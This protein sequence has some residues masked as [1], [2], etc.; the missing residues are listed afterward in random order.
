MNTGYFHKEYARSIKYNAKTIHL[1]ESEAWLLKRNIPYTG[2]FDVANCYPLLCCQNWD[3]LK[4]DIH[5]LSKKI[6]SLSIVTDPFAEIEKSNIANTFNIFKPFKKHFIVDL[7][8]KN[9]FN[10]HH[11]R[12]ISRSLKKNIEL[13]HCENPLEYIDQWDSLY[14]GLINRHNI[15]KSISFSRSLF[16]NQFKVPGIFVFR[17]VRDNETIGMAL[18]YVSNRNAYY[19]LTA[20]SDIGYKTGCSYAL[21]N[22]SLNFFRENGTYKA[23]LG[24]GSGL[25]EN[26]NDGLTKFKAGWS[27]Y[28]KT[29]FFCGKIINHCE[30]DNIIKKSKNYSSF[31]A[32]RNPNE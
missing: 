11:K 20:Y 3:K 31:P 10:L 1:K 7:K 12:E 8:S 21:M 30:Y 6:V 13:E 26:K 19:H 24:S 15:R 18:W 32:Y 29:A 16:I 17:A 14:T 28:T 2:L 27:N 5:N 23:S 22:F 4:Y 9:N 25:V